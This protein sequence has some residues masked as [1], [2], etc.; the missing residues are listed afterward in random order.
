MTYEK[1]QGL[2]INLAAYLLA[3]AIGFVPY[4]FLS[5]SLGYIVSIFAFTVVSTIALYV[6]CVIFK[7]TSLYDPYWSVAPLVMTIIHMVR[8]GV[9]TINSLIFS[10]LILIYSMRLTINWFMTY[11]GVESKYEDWRYKQYRAKYGR[12]QF[13]IINFF[14]LLLIPTLVVYFALIPGLLFMASRTFNP[15]SIIG[16]AFMLAG[17]ILEFVADHQ[18]HKFIK[19]CNDHTKVCNI[20]LWNYSRHPNYLGEL[21]F[22]FG[23][24]ICQLVLLNN[25]WMYALG[26][27]PMLLLFL[28]ISIPMMEK[29]NTKRR[30]EYIEYK[31]KT[32]MLL[33][34]P[35][36]KQ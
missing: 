3:F 32:S 28:F 15:L 31:R 4:Y 26:F 22:W 19:E 23:V 36:K 1:K 8:F 14:G 6:I 21:S 2:L 18:S 24:A 34:L 7:N 25:Y 17:P 35:R 33:I 12:I 30:P 5:E 16:F 11:K 20:G 27:I 9:Y 10:I 29:H 13:E